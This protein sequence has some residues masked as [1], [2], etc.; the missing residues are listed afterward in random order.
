MSRLAGCPSV[1]FLA[2]P[3]KKFSIGTLIRE[4]LHCAVHFFAQE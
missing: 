2:I 1:F 3:G 4:G